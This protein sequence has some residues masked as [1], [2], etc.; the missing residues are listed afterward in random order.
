MTPWIRL[1]FLAAGAVNIVGMLVISRAFTNE[2]LASADPVVFSA[3][4]QAMILVWGLAYIAAAAHWQALPWLCLVFFVEKMFYVGA[5][6]VWWTN[7]ADRFAS[8]LDQDPLTAVFL[9][10]Y[11]ANDLAF[12]LLFLM[13]AVLALRSH[14]SP[15]PA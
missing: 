2:T 14:T 12:G 11:G 3:F 7:S 13:A 8:I 9:A 10:G 1:A 6:V 15:A 4:G 5:W